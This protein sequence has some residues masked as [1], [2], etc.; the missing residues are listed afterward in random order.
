MKALFIDRGPEADLYVNPNVTEE[1]Y[2]AIVNY[3]TAKVPFP[4]ETS[5]PA[6]VISP[7][8]LTLRST[9]GGTKIGGVWSNTELQVE[10]IDGA[11][12]KIA[13]W[14]SSDPT[15]IRIGG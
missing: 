15:L 6:K 4:E 5:R 9:S 11:F 12:C 2:Q 1:Q 8:G 13:A 14:V 10:T 7:A 3:L